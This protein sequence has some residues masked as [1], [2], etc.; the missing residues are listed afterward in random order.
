MKPK[1]DL[2][3]PVLLGAYFGVEIL[4]GETT[5]D[6]ASTVLNAADR[7]GNLFRKLQVLDTTLV[8]TVA[9]V[10]FRSDLTGAY[11]LLRSL[12]SRGVIVEMGGAY[13]THLSNG[14]SGR[15]P[16]STMCSAVKIGFGQ[17]YA[18]TKIKRWRQ[19]FAA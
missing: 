18:G 2:V 7:A 11:A 4:R 5:K 16:T 12:T 15:I 9:F 1:A 14:R 3:E 17:V 8:G 6:V 19:Q 10:R 13:I